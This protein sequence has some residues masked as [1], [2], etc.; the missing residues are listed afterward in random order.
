[1]G[2]KQ[3]KFTLESNIYKPDLYLNNLNSMIAHE[4]INPN[5]LIK[6]PQKPNPS[7]NKVSHVTIYIA[8]Y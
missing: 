3:T 5:P 6:V 4:S 7:S 8:F 1:M 2:C